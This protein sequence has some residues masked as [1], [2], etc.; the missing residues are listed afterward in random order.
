MN[1]EPQKRNFSIYASDKD[2]IRAFGNVSVM[3][4]AYGQPPPRRSR[5]NEVINRLIAA[6]YILKDGE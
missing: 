1:E 6:Y 2:I 4:L 5:L 3:S